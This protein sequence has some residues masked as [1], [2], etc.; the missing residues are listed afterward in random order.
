MCVIT[1][2]IEHVEFLQERAS[3]ANTY[4]TFIIYSVTKNL[5]QIRVITVMKNYGELHEKAMNT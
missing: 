5:H 4:C 3:E 2:L 1:Q